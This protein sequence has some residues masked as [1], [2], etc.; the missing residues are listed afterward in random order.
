MGLCTESLSNWRRVWK[1]FSVRGLPVGMEELYGVEFPDNR[2]VGQDGID[3]I[4][5]DH[6]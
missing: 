6:R 3:P 4:S 2:R 1:E 5:G